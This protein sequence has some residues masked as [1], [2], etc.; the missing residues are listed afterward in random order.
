[1]RL[2]H[3]ISSVNPKGGGPMEGVQQIGRQLIAMGHTVEVLS[4][5]DPASPFVQAFPLTVHAL[6]P[7]AGAYQYNTRLVPWLQAHAKAYD[8]IVVNGIWQYH[9]FGSWR[10]LHRMGVPYYIYTHGMLDPWFRR[11]YPL[12]HLKK[13][14]YWPWAE[15]RVLR[16]AKGVL[17][18]CE[19]ERLLARQS[20]WLY[21]AREAVVSYGTKSPPAN[22]AE[23]RA[24]FL[25]EHP[26]LQG[27]RVLLFLSRIQYKK[28]CDLL[29][30]AFAKVAARDPAL[31]L[32]M[33]GPDQTGWASELQALAQA[34]GVADRISWPG[35][36]QGDAKWGA[37]YAAEAFALSSHQENF[38]IAV[39]EAMGCGLPVLIS[40]K[41]NIWREIKSDGAGIVNTDTVEGTVQTL[42]QWLDMDTQAQK[43]MGQ[44]A[45]AS[46]EKRFTVEAMAA[47]LLH[48]VSGEQP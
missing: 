32:L 48:I 8:A 26:Q 14:L 35:M 23:L 36:L 4:L 38:G 20:F 24:R 6:G 28:G 29:I 11:N 34:R 22:A 5:D 30:E 40:D 44:R 21:R 17:F 45:R 18:T 3:I 27:K 47:S 31:H 12:K 25:A 39:A 43:A 13:W 10:A 41:V 7:S 37:F 33:A 15:Y 46:F 1:M 9:S 2:L 16:D 19:E 42:Q